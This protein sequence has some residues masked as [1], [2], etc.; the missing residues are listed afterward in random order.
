LED[1]AHPGFSYSQK[2]HLTTRMI[3]EHG[4]MTF[5]EIQKALGISASTV[6]SILRKQFGVS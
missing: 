5:V 3:K 4:N 1:E 6:N 2:R